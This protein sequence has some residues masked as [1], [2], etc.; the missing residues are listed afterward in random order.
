MRRN[1]GFLLFEMIAAI[2][3]LSVASSIVFSV[4]LSSAAKVRELDN[5]VTAKII[6]ANQLAKL[7]HSIR[8]DLPVTAGEKIPIVSPMGERL[9]ELEA[10]GRME[11]FRPGLK[12]LEIVVKW[13]ERRGMRSVK[14]CSLVAR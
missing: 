1:K 8:E 12:R 11:D 6:A 3:V 13:K 5:A 7:E 9:R 4:L 10:S 14:L 2:F